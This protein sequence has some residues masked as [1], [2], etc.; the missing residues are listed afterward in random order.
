M[1]I[2]KTTF[3]FIAGA[4]HTAWSWHRIVPLVEAHGMVSL[5][6]DLP[7]MGQNRSIAAADATLALWGDYVAD[8]VRAAEAPVILVGHSRGG[9]VIGEAAERVPDL[10]AGLIYVSGL[11][12]PPGCTAV[13]IM[14]AGDA[15]GGPSPTGDGKAVQISAEAAI[16]LFYN[17]CSPAD[18]AEAVSHL[19]LEPMAPNI[20]P[21]TVTADHWLRVPRGYVETSDDRTLDIAKQRAMQATAPCDPVETLDADHSPFLSAAPQLADALLSMAAR[22]VHPA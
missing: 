11:I 17:R 21:A 2:E 4:L 14:G 5:T 8:L 10:I 12:I 18:A 1:T 3:I 20:T 15:Q 16:P 13:E 19:C 6:P 9:L 22:F 7:G